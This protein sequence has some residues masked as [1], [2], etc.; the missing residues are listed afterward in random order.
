MLYKENKILNEENMLL[1]QYHK[2][3][4]LHGSGGRHAN[5]ASAKVRKTNNVLFLFKVIIGTKLKSC[6]F[7]F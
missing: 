5:S 4:S 7:N 3:R 1:R 6:K 2:E